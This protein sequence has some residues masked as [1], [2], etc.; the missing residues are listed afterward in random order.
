M[1]KISSRRVPAVSLWVTI[2]FT[3]IGTLVTGIYFAFDNRQNAA[4]GLIN[5]GW[6]Y[7][8]LSAMGTIIVALVYAA[9]C[10]AGLKMFLKE[11]QW[12]TVIGA[13]VGFLV[14]AG[15][16]AAQ[17]IS[18]L[19]PTGTAAIGRT[20]G[21]VGVIIILVWMVFHSIKNPDRIEAA[22]D[23][24]IMHELAEVDLNTIN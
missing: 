1:A 13:I 9:L 7:E 17:F 18:G 4:L 20:A 22:A 6:G 3:L 2:I 5:A 8:I 15:A 12:L 21:I 16:V 10:I 14:A 23:H 11:G 19:A 24:A